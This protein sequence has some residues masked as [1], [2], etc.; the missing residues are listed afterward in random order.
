MTRTEERLIDALGAVGRGVRE[1]TLPP[2]PAHG[3]AAKPGRWGRWLAPLAA[4]ASVVLVVVVVSAVHLFSGRPGGAVG[5]PRYY[6]T[7]EE[8]GI[9]IR[10][11]A[12]GAVTG[13]V[14]NQAP[15]GNGYGPG[16]GSYGRYAA[17][18]AAADGGREFF[19]AFS[20]TVASHAQKTWLYSFRLTDAGRVTRLAPVRGGAFRGLL[21]GSDMAVS[22]DGSKVALTLYPLLIPSQGAKPAEV[23]V[24]DLATGTRALWTD[25]LRHGSLSAR[26]PSVSWA[27][28]GR[29]LVFVS[30]WCQIGVYGSQYCTPGPHYA[31]VRTLRLTAGGGRL[32]PGRVLLAD[33][34]RYPY[35][36]QARPGPGGRSLIVVVLTG[37]A[38]GTAYPLPPDLRVISVPLAGGRPRLLYRG[39]VDRHADVFLG[40]DA[41]GRYLLLAWARNGWLDHGRLRPLP[42]QGGAAFADAW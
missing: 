11:T 29:S 21:A 4:A 32:S 28:D 8:G 15:G 2:L 22:P 35:I 14:P 13:K 34:R 10:A 23:G 16:G 31:Q 41:S 42:P 25:S 40:S 33:S 5:P 12:T 38:V 18:V 26:I 24:L 3:P 7:V 27:A 1:E 17:S 30:L 19:A 6:A 20:G 9:V 39:A 37:H 36:I